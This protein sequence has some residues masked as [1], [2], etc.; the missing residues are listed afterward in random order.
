MLEKLE[1]FVTM[2]LTNL[3]LKLHATNYTEIQTLYHSHKE[4]NVIINS[5]G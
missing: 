4:D 3:R 2:V 1:Q 5:S